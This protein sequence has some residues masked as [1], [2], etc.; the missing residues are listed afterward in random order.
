[1]R[2]LG[3]AIT[4]SFPVPTIAQAAARIRKNKAMTVKATQAA[5]A[6]KLDNSL[7]DLSASDDRRCQNLIETVNN[8]NRAVLPIM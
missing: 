4:L 6:A 5:A 2:L 3:D 1:M 7:S 8:A